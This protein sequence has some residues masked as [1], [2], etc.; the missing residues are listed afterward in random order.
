MA[1]NSR[2][3]E[4][5]R[6]EKMKT[7]AVACQSGSDYVTACM[8]LG[9]EPELNDLY[10]QGLAEKQ[11]IEWAKKSS[12]LNGKNFENYKTLIRA[13]KRENVNVT[14]LKE[15]TATKRRHI[16]NILHY[17]SLNGPKGIKI[18]TLSADAETI[19]RIYRDH[20]L[21]ALETHPDL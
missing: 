14:H 9:I 17:S 12:R 6:F 2:L 20:D 11:S 18:P 8:E 1:K 5:A 15:D 19:G 16:L 13:V 10:E 4:I 3:E 21:R 7:G